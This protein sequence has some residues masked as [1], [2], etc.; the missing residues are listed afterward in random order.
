MT[1]KAIL[2]YYEAVHFTANS[3]KAQTTT[4]QRVDVPIQQATIL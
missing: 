2:E 1:A 3:A 4:T